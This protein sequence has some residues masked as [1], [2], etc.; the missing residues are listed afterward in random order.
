MD[1]KLDCVLVSLL[2]LESLQ[3]RGKKVKMAA[4]MRWRQKT[5]ELQPHRCSHRLAL[6]QIVWSPCLPSR[7]VVVAGKL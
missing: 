1:M 7:I 3:D 5:V 4:R 6:V 2:C